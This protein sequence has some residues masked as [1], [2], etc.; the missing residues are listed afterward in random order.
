MLIK[1]NVIILEGI[2]VDLTNKRLI[3]GKCKGIITY[4]DAIKRTD[5][6]IQYFIQSLITQIILL[7]FIINILVYFS[8]LL[9]KD[10]DF[11]LEPCY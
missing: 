6:L 8:S 4:I 10:R 3:I 7:H 2:I 5:I 1:N 9:L 11:I